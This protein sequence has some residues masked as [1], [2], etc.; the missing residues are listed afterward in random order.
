M[1]NDKVDVVIVG[2]GASGSVFAAVLAKAG[3]K[4]VLLEAGPDWQLGDLISS[5]IWGRRIKPAGPPFLLEGK[6]PYGCIRPGG[7]LA[8]RRCIILPISHDSCPTTSRS[9]ALTAKAWIGRSTTPTSRPIGT[10]LPRMSVF[11]ATP[12]PK[13]SGARPESHTPCR[14]CERFRVER[15]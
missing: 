1:A 6:N 11:P 14:R 4:V 15:L 13:K 7:A 2:A 12:R 10:R 9:K 8:A 5:D 3:K